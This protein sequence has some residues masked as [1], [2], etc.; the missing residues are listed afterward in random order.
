MLSGRT[1]SLIATVISLAGCGTTA[2]EAYVATGPLARVLVDSSGAIFLNARPISRPALVE[3]LQALHAAG[4]AVIYSRRPY[5][6][7]PIPAQAAVVK[8]VMTAIINAKLPVRLIHPDSLSLPDSLL[9][10]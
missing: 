10:R 5:S 3:S 7:D 2:K 1:A 4:G 9:R 6:A 8:D